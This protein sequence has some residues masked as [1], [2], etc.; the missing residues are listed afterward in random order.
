MILLGKFANLFVDSL[1][2][3]LIVN[4]LI[5]DLLYFAGYFEPVEINYS[6]KQTYIHTGNMQSAGAYS[7]FSA[8]GE[9]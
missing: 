3:I 5:I 1:L 8:R 7:G 2:V 4:E 9:G 6:H